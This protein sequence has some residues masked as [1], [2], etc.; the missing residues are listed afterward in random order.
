M[1]VSL[2]NRHV[3]LCLRGSAATPSDHLQAKL[4]QHGGNVNARDT[5]GYP[6]IVAAAY[7]GQLQD[8]KVKNAQNERKLI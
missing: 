7:G 2:S 4:N 1:Y 8:V 6:L 5:D 3:V